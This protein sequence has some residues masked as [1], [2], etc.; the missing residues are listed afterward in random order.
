MDGPDGGRFPSTMNG[1]DTQRFLVRW[2]A[3]STGPSIRAGSVDAAGDAGPS[4]TGNGGW[5][6]VDS[7]QTPTLEMVAEPGSGTI[8]DVDVQVQQWVTTAG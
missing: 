4:V 7:C 8:A 5:M 1:C 6:D 3:Q 2:Q